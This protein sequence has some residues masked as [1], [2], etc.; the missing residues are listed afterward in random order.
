MKGI[1]KNK[2]A[3]MKYTSHWSETHSTG[4]IVN[5]IVITLWGD[6]F[7]MYINAKSL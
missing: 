2:L 3:V 1:K 5:T 6:H 4:Y 7:K